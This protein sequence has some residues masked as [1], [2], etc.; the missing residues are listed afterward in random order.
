MVPAIHPVPPGGLP[1]SEHP[2]RSSQL[3]LLCHT[4]PYTG[5]QGL[6]SFSH[7]IQKTKDFKSGSMGV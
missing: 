2:T 3:T 5:F 7:S 6:T 4:L 1:H